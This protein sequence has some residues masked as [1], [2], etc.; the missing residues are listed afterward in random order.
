[1]YCLDIEDSKIGLLQTARELG[2]KI[3][4]YSP[5]ARGMV[6]GMY[7]RRAYVNFLTLFSPLCQKSPDDFEKGDFR[8]MIPRQVL[9]AIT[10]VVFF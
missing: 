5:L 7:V 4:A 9:E 6:T 1:M 8:T 10:F 2:V 3:V